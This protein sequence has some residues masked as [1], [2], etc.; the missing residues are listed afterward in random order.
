MLLISTFF[1]CQKEVKVVVFCSFNYEKLRPD[2]NCMSSI[3]LI[4]STVNDKFESIKYYNAGRLIR[5]DSILELSGMNFYLSSTFFPTDTLFRVSVLVNDTTRSFVFKKVGGV[6]DLIFI[7][8]AD[9]G[10]QIKINFTRSGTLFTER[11]DIVFLR[12]ILSR[13]DSLE[14]LGDYI[15]LRYKYS[16]GGLYCEIFEGHDYLEGIGKSGEHNILMNNGN[17]YLDLP[18]IEDRVILPLSHQLNIQMKPS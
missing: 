15:V 7:E 9:G 8:S 2:S 10:D 6:Y 11:I 4:A 17:I 3:K 18:L 5:V 1:A 13:F 14:K 12:S 16:A